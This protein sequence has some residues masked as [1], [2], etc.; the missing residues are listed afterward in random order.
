MNRQKFLA[1]LSKLLGFMSSW[2]REAEMNKYTA[3]L[4]AA[5]D[6]AALIE[7]LGTPTQIAI[8][9]ALGYKPSPRPGTQP[10]EPE[11]A[12]EPEP[13]PPPKKKRGEDEI[14]TDVEFDYGM[15][16][17]LLMGEPVAAAVESA[18]KGEYL[19]DPDLSLD[20][21]LREVR[22]DGGTG[23]ELSEDGEPDA[24]TGAEAEPAGPEAEASEPA[25]ETVAGPGDAAAEPEA[26]P[27]EEAQPEQ[28]PSEAGAEAGGPEAEAAPGAES[29]AAEQAVAGTEPETAGDEPG[30]EPDGDEAA[31]ESE[32]EAAGGAEAD[33][34]AE[35]E[36]D[37]AGDATE[38]T[39]EG[40]P[41]FDAATAPLP[42]TVK[43]AGNGDAE[44]EPPAGDADAPEPEAKHPPHLV[45]DP[46]NF[47]PLPEDK[48]ADDGE[49]AETG[50]TERP[51]RR[52]VGIAVY[53][54]FSLVIGIPVTLL[55]VLTGVPVLLL[56]LGIIAGTVYAAV[57]I[58]A[59]L[60]MVS[61]ILLIAGAGLAIGGVGLLVAWLGLWLSIELGSLWINAVMIKLGRAL[62][63]KREADVQ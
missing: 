24:E 20:E 9:I 6:E 63:F 32:Q 43:S 33:T 1:E 18:F 49:A 4:D 57:H 2:D 56:G 62:C 19:P 42:E 7:S 21:I 41:V 36:E 55:L 38:E 22:G 3:M 47:A 34:P 26:A 45:F 23:G 29:S 13:P 15:E 14:V 37:A 46:A 11:P 39:P 30:A 53:V 59:A 54:L 10:P 31:P 28:T 16:L 25:A 44:A 40:G 12:P 51:A 8:S 58:I 60:S 35:P 48:A 5:E 61:D 27:E 50:G 17:A 52:P